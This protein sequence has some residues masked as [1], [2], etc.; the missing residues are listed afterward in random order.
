MQLT[1]RCGGGAMSQVKVMEILG[2]KAR[3]SESLRECIGDDGPRP[4]NCRFR[5]VL[6]AAIDHLQNRMLHFETPCVPR[7][8]NPWPSLRSCTR[9]RWWRLSAPRHAKLSDPQDG[10]KSSADWGPDPSQMSYDA[11][12][13]FASA[14]TMHRVG[15]S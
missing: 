5:I 4:L 13:G 9:P 11:A 6:P 12:N 15:V 10:N 14:C 8:G 3:N 7:R 1:G 2:Q